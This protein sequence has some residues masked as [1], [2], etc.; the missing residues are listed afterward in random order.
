[1][2][3][4][5]LTAD[6]MSALFSLGVEDIDLV[7]KEVPGDTP[8]QRL[9]SVL[10]LQGVASYLSSGAARINNDRLNEA[11][12]HYDAESGNFTR[13]LKQWSGEVSGSR[14]AG[15][16]VLTTRGLNSAKELIK[17]MLAED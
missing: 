8:R 3:R 7:A 15:D 10:L 14:S 2:T 6:Q 9:K 1:M 17:E 12:R 16:L 13:D 5:G 11:I 4:N